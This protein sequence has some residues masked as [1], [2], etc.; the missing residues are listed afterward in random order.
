M[1]F[2]YANQ[3]S[4]CET[5]EYISRKS[6]PLN[7]D[8]EVWFSPGAIFFFFFIRWQIK[9]PKSRE[10]TR[11]GTDKAWNGLPSVICRKAEKIV[12]QLVIN[13]ATRWLIQNFLQ[14]LQCEAHFRKVVRESW[15]DKYNRE[16]WFI[17]D[18]HCSL[19]RCCAN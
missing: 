8:S 13:F 12:R 6:W 4:I 5:N 17:T 10:R 9:A 7:Y 3:M 14:S 18:A 15:V 1:W 19:W 11:P 2:K 16:W